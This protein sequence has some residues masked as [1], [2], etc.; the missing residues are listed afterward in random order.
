MNIIHYISRN[1]LWIKQG[2]LKRKQNKT[3]QK[4]MILRQKLKNKKTNLWSRIPHAHI[5]KVDK[6]LSQMWEFRRYLGNLIISN[7]TSGCRNTLLWQY[8]FIYLYSV[9]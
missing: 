2:K 9:V 1:E 4:E 3:K 8:I 5:Y 7:V 6:C